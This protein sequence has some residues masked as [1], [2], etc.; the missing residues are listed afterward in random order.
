MDGLDAGP[1]GSQKV[2]ITFSLSKGGVLTV[3]MKYKS[4]TEKHEIDYKKTQ[5]AE[6][7]IDL[8]VA[9]SI[10]KEDADKEQYET[11]L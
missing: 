7:D 5:A 4:R 10:G 3:I 8:M 2:D 9:D 6:I 11:I 1:A